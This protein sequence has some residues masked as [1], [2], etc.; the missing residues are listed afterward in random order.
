MMDSELAKQLQRE[1]ELRL[2]EGAPAPVNRETPAWGAQKRLEHE[3]TLPG[4]GRIP[5][6]RID[7]PLALNNAHVEALDPTPDLRA[8]FHEYN[9]TFFEGRLEA[10]EVR[11]SPRMTRCAGLCLFESGGYCSIRLSAP[12][13]RLR[14]RSDF[15]DT[16]LVR[17]LVNMAGVIKSYTI[18]VWTWTRDFA[19]WGGEN[20]V[21]QHEMIHAYLFITQ[22][23]R[24]REGHGA[25]FQRMMHHINAIA[26]TSISV[27]H[28]FHDEVRNCLALPSFENSNPP[29]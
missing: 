17:I 24:D 27:F 5:I 4:K 14:P 15:N 29:T 7:R 9:G 10:C 20:D 12:L 18:R 26:G 19:G 16:L 8:L 11:W 1:E 13:L 6:P 23:N 25:E 21:R 3:K 28:T 2:V 22:N